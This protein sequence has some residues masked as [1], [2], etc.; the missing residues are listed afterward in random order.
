[1]NDSSSAPVASLPQRLTLDDAVVALGQLER[2]TSSQ[3][4]T[5]A[6]VDASTLQDFDSSA[7]AVLLELRRSLLAQ[8]KTLQVRHWPQRLR[9][10]VALYGVAELLQA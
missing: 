3:P 10:L 6:L 1:M 5:T 7:V 9:D 4:G 8:G 2:E